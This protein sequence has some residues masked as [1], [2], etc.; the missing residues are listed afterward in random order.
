M[1]TTGHFYL[2]ITNPTI[3]FSKLVKANEQ[4][5]YIAAGITHSPNSSLNDA[6]VVKAAVRFVS[7]SFTETHLNTFS[8]DVVLEKDDGS[9]ESTER[10]DA[11]KYRG[12]VTFC[13][14]PVLAGSTLNILQLEESPAI[15]SL[16]DITGTRILVK[17]IQDK[18]V[19]IPDGCNGIYYFKLEQHGQLVSR[20]K[21][22][23][24]SN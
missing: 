21:I 17:E 14:N 8:C 1:H 15:F 12:G 23:I 13:P 16:Y 19:Q 9:L 22:L 3:Y 6:W 2:R 7:G 11:L 10:S 20:G 4:D 5:G 24:V 18:K